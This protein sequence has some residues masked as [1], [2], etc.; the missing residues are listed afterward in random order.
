MTYKQVKMTYQL[1]DQRTNLIDWLSVW[2]TDWLIVNWS[3]NGSYGRPVDLHIDLFVLSL[4]HW[5]NHPFILIGWGRCKRRAGYTGTS[6]AQGMQEYSWT[7][8]SSST[9]DKFLTLF[10]YR[11]FVQKKNDRWVKSYI[12]NSFSYW[13]RKVNDVVNLVTSLVF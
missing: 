6:R 5:S 3:S 10:R 1:V 9:R 4:F 8:I 2:Q 13:R 12:Q 11:V 7:S